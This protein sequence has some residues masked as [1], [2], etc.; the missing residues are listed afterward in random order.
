MKF[1]SRLCT[2]LTTLI[3]LASGVAFC[4]WMASVPAVSHAQEQDWM[5]ESDQNTKSIAGT[6][7]RRFWDFALSK[8]NPHRSN[9]PRA[10][11][12]FDQ[13]Q[14]GTLE[15]SLY[16]V[17]SGRIDFDASPATGIG[18]EHLSI[19][20]REAYFTYNLD[21]LHF[22]FGRINIRDGVALAYNPSDVFRSGSLPT[23][24]TEDPSRLRESRLG[25][26][27]IQAR[28]NG[29]FGHIAG[30]AAPAITDAQ[31]PVWY[32]PQLGAVNGR[33]PQIYFKYTPP[34]WHDLYTNF[35][36]H[37]V[38][39]TSS[40]FAFNLSQNLGQRWMSYAEFASVRTDALSANQ[41]NIWQTKHQYQQAAIGTSYSNEKRQTMS[42]E[43]QFNGAGLNQSQW[44]NEWQKADGV[45][46]AQR[47][48]RIG[49][50]QDP[51]SRESL[52]ALLQWDQLTS[53]HDDLTCLY[54]L[55][56][57]DKSHLQWCEWRYKQ[58]RQEWSV[59]LTHLAGQPRSE[60]G[61]AQQ[62]LS[63]GAKL[64]LFY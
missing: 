5:P 15:Q 35:I 20:L 38:A 64:R 28:T 57:I 54:R 3:P 16:W 12:G 6:S 42:L 43:Y 9:S 33:E 48:M 60:F 41:A 62:P 11:L 52:T 61:A 23:R 4:L 30:I 53:P 45:A 13:Y 49:R 26:V 34:R 63:L 14:S 27:A 46:I 32:D 56:L 21:Q 37:R 39:K 17:L 7:G 58:D 40:T 2:L 22:D 10:N 44:N 55:S 25:L 36:V 59:S 51:L 31:S 19:A 29:S 1:P 47:F 18:H 50:Q 24:R 8:N